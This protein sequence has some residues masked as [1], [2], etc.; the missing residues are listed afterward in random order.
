MRLSEIFNLKEEISTPGAT[1]TGNIT[2]VSG[3][4]KFMGVLPK[5]RKKIKVEIEKDEE[6]T[7][8]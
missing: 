5:K 3:H 7:K 1:G 2:R 6:P 8:P 4:S